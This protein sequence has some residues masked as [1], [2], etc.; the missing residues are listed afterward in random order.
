MLLKNKPLS[1][2]MSP[3]MLPWFILLNGYDDMFDYKLETER[4]NA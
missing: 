3:W 1:L 2:I 4:P